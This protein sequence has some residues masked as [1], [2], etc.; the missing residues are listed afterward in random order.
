VWCH[1]FRCSILSLHVCIPFNRGHPCIGGIKISWITAPSAGGMLFPPW[2]HWARC[3]HGAWSSCSQKKEYVVYFFWTPYLVWNWN[4]SILCVSD[5]HFISLWHP[6]SASDK[7]VRYWIPLDALRKCDAHMQGSHR[8]GRYKLSSPLDSLMQWVS[9]FLR[10]S[11]FLVSSL[12]FII[13]WRAL[14]G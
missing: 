4:T 10:D 13:I 12:G 5:K 9:N 14:I 3:Q 7:H 8:A 2:F 6:G 1:T 11:F